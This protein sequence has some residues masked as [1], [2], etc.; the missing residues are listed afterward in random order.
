MKTNI[1]KDSNLES[2]K[3]N[4][5][6]TV[7]IPKHYIG[8]YNGISKLGDIGSLEFI[9]AGGII[10]YLNALSD[11]I[12]RDGVS[13]IHPANPEILSREKLN[14]VIVSITS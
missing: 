14:R 13:A 5:E 8:F 10:G 6:L 3:V 7:S 11:E 9:A 2:D 12:Q 4:V 1:Q